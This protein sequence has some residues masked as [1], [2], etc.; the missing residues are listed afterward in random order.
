MEDAVGHIAMTVLRRFLPPVGVV[1]RYATGG[2]IIVIFVMTA[3]IA[4]VVAAWFALSEVYGAAMASLVVALSCLVLALVT[5]GV[6]MLLNRL[7]RERRARQARLRA[8]AGPTP[9]AELVDMALK[10]LPGLVKEKPILTLLCVAGAVFMAT[11][12]Q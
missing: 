6:T 5:W 9:E 8:A 2:V 12:S 10:A 7:A 4:G 1:N 11:R 3:Y